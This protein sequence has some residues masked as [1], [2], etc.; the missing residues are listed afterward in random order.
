LAIERG[1]VNANE[2]YQPYGAVFMSRLAVVS[3]VFASFS[4]AHA[5]DP[6]PRSLEVSTSE[7]RRAEGL[8]RRLGDSAFQIREQAS[9]ELGKMGRLA[10]PVVEHVLTT[11]ED[12]EVRARC[13][14]LLPKAVAADQR[15]RLDAFL[16]DVDGKYE[17]DLVGWNEMARA[18]G[19]GKPARELFAEMV[20]AKSNADLLTALRM[21]AVLAPR[22]A[23]RRIE[24]Y[25]RMYG[26]NPERNRSFP[27][28]PE[29]AALILA[30]VCSTTQPDRRYYYATYYPLQQ[31]SDLRNALTGDK[32]GKEAAFRKL[33]VHWLASRTDPTEVGMAMSTAANLNLKELPAG[34]IAARLLVPDGTGKLPAPAPA[35]TKMQ[36]L[37]Y[38]AKTGDRTY[39]AVI[40]KS[41][42][43]GEGTAVA[44]VVNGVVQRS[45][46]K[47]RDTALA[48]AA[49]LTGQEP[50]AYGFDTQNPNELSKYSYFNYTF[51]SDEK[52]KAAFVKWA[53]WEARQKK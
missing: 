4:A 39:L 28:L 18:A 5:A 35:F 8:A 9:R 50:K 48:M 36:A 43:D 15:A 24:V 22:V 46:V 25:T 52:R 3:F 53:F 40:R 33:V 1:I 42:D 12:P 31:S 21:P 32:D 41:F 16:A 30:E 38:L 51:P 45:D 6:D 44:R 19:P 27:S 10:L 17:H 20:K 34:S 37:G 47:V 11:T 26:Q 49:L 2:L 7:L 23:A 13:E 14:W 29:M